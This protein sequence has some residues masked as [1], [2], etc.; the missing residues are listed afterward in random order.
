MIH[1]KSPIDDK[2]NKSERAGNRECHAKQASL[3]D[4]HSQK[5]PQK[6]STNTYLESAFKTTINFDSSDN[7]HLFIVFSHKIVGPLE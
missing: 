6:S 2:G 5:V 1:K 4:L 7:F 3:Y